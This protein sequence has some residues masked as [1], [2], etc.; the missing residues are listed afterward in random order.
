MKITW[1]EPESIITGIFRG[2]NNGGLLCSDLFSFFLLLREAGHLKRLLLFPS[3]L[4]RL[5]EEKFK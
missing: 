3:L 5:R 4:C 1:P 2:L